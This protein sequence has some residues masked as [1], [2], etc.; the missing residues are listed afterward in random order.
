MMTT[1]R[2]ATCTSAGDAEG[3]AC[4]ARE[5]VR[6]R[7]AAP[8]S[9]IAAAAVGE[10]LRALPGGDGGR[11]AVIGLGD[12]PLPLL[13]DVVEQSRTGFV[14]PVKFPAASASA[15]TG[16]ICI[17]HGL[18]GPTLCLTMPPRRAAPV[19][20]LMAERWIAEGII[21]ACAICW[22]TRRGDAVTATCMLLAPS[23][24]TAEGASLDD[25][26]ERVLAGVASGDGEPA[27]DIGEHL[28]EVPA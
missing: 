16:L 6:I 19:A 18:R 11:I 14:S 28:P 25:E 1:L 17:V 10:A 20:R 24:E 26:L 2:M 27:T 22:T 5:K 15:T 13:A 4:A 23:V 21:D 7:F 3:R 8:E 12:E 9:W